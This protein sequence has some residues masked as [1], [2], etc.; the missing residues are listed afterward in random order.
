VGRCTLHS[1]R[2][3][4]L[5]G[6]CR[7]CERSQHETAAGSSPSF[8]VRGIAQCNPRE[9]YRPPVPTKPINRLSAVR[10]WHERRGEACV[11][12][13]LFSKSFSRLTSPYLYSVPKPHSSRSLYC[14]GCPPHFNPSEMG[15]GENQ[16]QH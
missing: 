1:E 2:W 3:V 15:T 11:A 7:E 10:N 4:D 16:K 8:H 9:I 13:P 12:C 6:T 14:F 5:Q